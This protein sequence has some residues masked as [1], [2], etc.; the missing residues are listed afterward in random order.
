LD[1]ERYRKMMDLFAPEF[2]H[3]PHNLFAGC[4][5][6]EHCTADLYPA[7]WSPAAAEQLFE[8]LHKEIPWAQRD[9]VVYGKRYPQPRLVAWFGDRGASY[10]YSR[11]TLEPLPW[12]ESLTHIKRQVE[13]LAGTRF[14]SVLANLYRNGQDTNGWHSDDE[15][16]LGTNP[17]IASVSLGAV[18]RF[19]LRHKHSKATIR[20]DLPSGS[21]L[22]MAGNTQSQWQHQLPRTKKVDRP[23]INL[24]FRSVRIASGNN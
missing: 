11:L 3:T 13:Q 22:I 21:L 20:C 15:P 5:V 14:N 24:T 23:R 4:S 12:T 9:V 19:D 2:E 6:S 10:T 17:I 16:E 18:R 1:I 7:V 8:R